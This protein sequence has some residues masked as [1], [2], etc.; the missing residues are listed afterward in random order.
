[1]AKIFFAVSFIFSIYSLIF[2]PAGWLWAQ[3]FFKS[4]LASEQFEII[5]LI[6]YSS[7]STDESRPSPSTDN[8]GLKTKPSPKVWYK[9]WWSGTVTGAM[10]SGAFISMASNDEREGSR[11]PGSLIIEDPLLQ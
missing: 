5:N 4:S 7:A 9:K 6:T 1:M 3:N 10:G 11:A 2:V 8:L